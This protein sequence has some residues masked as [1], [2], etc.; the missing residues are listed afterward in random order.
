M[1]NESKALIP[2][3][4]QA[5]RPATDFCPG[6]PGGTGPHAWKSFF[7]QDHSAMYLRCSQCPATGYAT[8]TPQQRVWWI[9]GHQAAQQ[10]R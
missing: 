3:P 2:R 4:E 7:S 6:T 1:A 10:K 8:R 5:L 9:E